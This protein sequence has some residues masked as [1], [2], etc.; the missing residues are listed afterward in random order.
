MQIT[1]VNVPVPPQSLTQPEVVTNGLHNVQVQSAAPITQNSVAPSPKDEGSSR[2]KERRKEGRHPEHDQY[3][4]SEDA[5]TQGRGEN[6]N[7]S[8]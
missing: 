3:G 5:D 6:L 2:T 4:T 1:P 7:F 8:V